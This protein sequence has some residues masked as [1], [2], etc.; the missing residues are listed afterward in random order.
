MATVSEPSGRTTVTYEGNAMIGGRATPPTQEMT[1]MTDQGEDITAEQRHTTRTIESA[2]AK[3]PLSLKWAVEST[4]IPRDNGV[5]MARD[6]IQDQ[7]KCMSDGSLKETYGTSAAIFM[8]TE[9]DNRYAICNRTPGA[10]R[11][12]SSF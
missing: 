7:G 3:L 11:D 12:Q 8:G 10:T 4:I 5:A 1:V 9:E 6:I 2:I